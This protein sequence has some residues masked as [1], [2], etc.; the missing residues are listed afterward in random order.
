MNASITT[1]GKYDEQGHWVLTRMAI[2]DDNDQQIVIS[3]CEDGSYDF[4]SL[5]IEDDEPV[6][7]NIASFDQCWNAIPVLLGFTEGV[8]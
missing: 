4:S 7:S 5:L 2:V 1:S 8:S 3:L 6:K